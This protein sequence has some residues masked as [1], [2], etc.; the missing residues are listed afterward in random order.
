[1]FLQQFRKFSAIFSKRCSSVVSIPSS[2]IAHG[3]MLGF[4]FLPSYICPLFH[5][6]V[7]LSFYGILANF[8][9]LCLSILQFSLQLCKICCLTHSLNFKFLGVEFWISQSSIW[10]FIEFACS[11][12]AASCYLLILVILPFISIYIPFVLQS[13]SDNFNILYPRM[14]KSCWSLTEMLIHTLAFGRGPPTEFFCCS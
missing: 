8:F 14:S 1:M 9:Q 5:I 12:L 6:S 7:S 13:T 11:F 2:G 10:F 3:P 4:P